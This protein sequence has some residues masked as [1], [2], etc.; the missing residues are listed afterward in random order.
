MAKRRVGEEPVRWRA[1]VFLP[2]EPACFNRLAAGPMVFFNGFF[3]FIFSV[4]KCGKLEIPGI[5]VD[6]DTGK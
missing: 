5:D 3:Q 2:E 1:R 4:E 6:S